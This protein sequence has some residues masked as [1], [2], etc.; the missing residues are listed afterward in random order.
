MLGPAHKRV[1]RFR[2]LRVQRFRVQ[3]LNREGAKNAKVPY[4]PS[5]GQTPKEK[6]VA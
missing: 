2:G 5:A 3:N 1:Q 4:F 6:P